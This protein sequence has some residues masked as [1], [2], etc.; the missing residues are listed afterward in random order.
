MKHHDLNFTLNRGVLM[1][2]YQMDKY[3]N[4]NIPIDIIR[5][6]SADSDNPLFTTLPFVSISLTFVSTSL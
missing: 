5:Y 1:N 2:F 6:Y 3:L 4:K